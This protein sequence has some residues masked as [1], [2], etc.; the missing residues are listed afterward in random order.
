MQPISSHPEKAQR[1]SRNI[2]N[3]WPYHDTAR[4]PPQQLYHEPIPNRGRYGHVRTKNERVITSLQRVPLEYDHTNN[5]KQ[6]WPSNRVFK[7]TRRRQS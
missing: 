3:Y 4:K 7:N 6:V 2:K 1:L 5:D